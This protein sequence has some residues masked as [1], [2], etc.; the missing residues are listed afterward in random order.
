MGKT[1]TGA[2]KH[3]Q[4]SM[5]LVPMDSPGITVIRPL[6]VFGYDDAPGLSYVI[7][8]MIVTRN[9]YTILDFQTPRN[10]Y[11]TCKA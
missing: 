2:A 7:L 4:Q 9:V 6:T 5:I 8:R 10:I 11:D 1:D 3:K